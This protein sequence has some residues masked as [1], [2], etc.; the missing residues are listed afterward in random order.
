MSS[1]CQSDENEFDF[2]YCS[3]FPYYSRS[4][5]M[6]LRFYNMEIFCHAPSG[7]TYYLLWN[8]SVGMRDT[9]SVICLINGS[10]LDWLE[11]NREKTL[12]DMWSKVLSFVSLSDSLSSP[13]TSACALCLTMKSSYLQC[14]AALSF[15]MG[16]GRQCLSQIWERRWHHFHMGCFHKL[17]TGTACPSTALDTHKTK[18]HSHWEWKNNYKI[19][20][21]TSNWPFTHTCSYGGVWSRKWSFLF[22]LLFLFLNFEVFVAVYFTLKAD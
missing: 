16:R 17:Q 12:T 10:C 1:V 6:P 22:S 2:M 20:Q 4:I 11:K 9:C 18:F 5:R 3:D 14:R 13:P 19:S 21:K 7:K 15:R 8:Y